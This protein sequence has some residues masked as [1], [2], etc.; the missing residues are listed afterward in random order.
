MQVKILSYYATKDA[1]YNQ[2]PQLSHKSVNFIRKAHPRI[3]DNK[4]FRI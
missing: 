4:T 2:V 3:E 1:I